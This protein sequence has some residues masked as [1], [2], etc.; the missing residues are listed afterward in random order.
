MKKQIKTIIREWT[1][2]LYCKDHPG[3]EVELDDEDVIMVEACVDKWVPE[4][5]LT[6]Y[7]YRKGNKSTLTVSYPELKR[8][9]PDL[10]VKAIE[11]HKR[12][13]ARPDPLMGSCT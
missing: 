13:I 1:S 10:A 2:M 5:N 3:P 4:E 12:N 11:S 6:V 8:T 9:F 7:L